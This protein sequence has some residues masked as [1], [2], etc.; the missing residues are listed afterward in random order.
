MS[1]HITKISTQCTSKICNARKVHK[2]QLEYR[3]KDTVSVRNT[4]LFP[5]ITLLTPRESSR[6]LKHENYSVASITIVSL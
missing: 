6:F 5:L 2:T 1:L 4:D 3:F